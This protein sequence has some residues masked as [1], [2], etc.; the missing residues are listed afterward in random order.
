MPNIIQLAKE[1]ESVSDERLMQEINVPNVFPPH[2]SLGELQRREQE[3]A[4]HQSRVQQIPQGTVRDQLI[5][6]A[7]SG[8]GSIPQQQQTQPMPAAMAMAQQGGAPMDPSMMQ[9]GMPPQG[10]MPM[11]MPMGAMAEGGI[12]GYS[13]GGRIPGYQEGGQAQ[14]FSVSPEVFEE[15]MPSEEFVLGYSPAELDPEVPDP[16]EVDP[17]EELILKI[18]PMAVEVLEEERGRTGTLTPADRA[19][20][21]E[22]LAIA[23]RRAGQAARLRS[24]DRRYLGDMR[25][26]QRDFEDAMAQRIQDVE[27]YGE[28]YERLAGSRRRQIQRALDRYEDLDARTR[29]RYEG[30]AEDLTATQARD[31]LA[32]LAGIVGGAI[33]RGRF[34]SGGIG[35]GI[36]EG[37]PQLLSLRDR[38]RLQEIEIEDALA[39]LDETELSRILKTEEGLSE[40]D[41][42]TLDR[43][44]GIDERKSDLGIEQFTTLGEMLDR[45]RDVSRG[46]DESRVASE[47]L[48]DTAKLENLAKAAEIARERGDI[49]GY[50]DLLARLVT[51][52]GQVR[53]SPV[54]GSTVFGVK[55]DM[56]NQIMK[57]PELDSPGDR[58][59]TARIIA[60]G[61]GLFAQDPDSPEGTGFTSLERLNLFNQLARSS[62][63][64]IEQIMGTQ[65]V[66]EFTAARDFADS[67]AAE[68]QKALVEEQGYGINFSQGGLVPNEGY[69]TMQP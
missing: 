64:T 47:G 54:T 66:P 42:S 4:A 12:V 52:R 1:L 45:Q 44:F 9:G 61:L 48:V 31:R 26:R 14:G 7:L 57:I 33:S 29:E 50:A 43:M 68:A 8:I 49:G 19:V 28:S 5:S 18:A 60:V 51:L 46:I 2:L 6:R 27:D 15:F 65:P 69:L 3:R 38:Q 35:G 23:Q 25:G 13:N 22:R 53:P 34:Q 39:D 16:Q 20:A 62:G 11:Q 41:M 58:Y 21:A 63:F 67:E 30:R 37:I 10:G 55:Q 36:A 59:E 17:L 40:L 32:L 24:G 56:V